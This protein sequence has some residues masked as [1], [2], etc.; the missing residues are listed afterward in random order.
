[1]VQNGVFFA[2]K[3]QIFL[4]KEAQRPPNGKGQNSG[5]PHQHRVFGLPKVQE[6]GCKKCKMRCKKG[7]KGR[8]VPYDGLLP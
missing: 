8:I 6:W 5:N 1:M 2:Q 3:E 4:K 7:C